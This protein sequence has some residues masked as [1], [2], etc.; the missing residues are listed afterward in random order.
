MAPSMGV[1]LLLLLP[2]AQGVREQH[3][4]TVVAS[5]HDLRVAIN[6][7]AQITFHVEG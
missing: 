7:S 5:Q 6:T 1:V 2:L 3:N 4:V